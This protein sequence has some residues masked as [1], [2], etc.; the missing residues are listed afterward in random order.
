MK[1]I[2]LFYGSDRAF[3]EI[4]PKSYKNLSLIATQ[5]D[6][7]NKK[8]EMIITGLPQQETKMEKTKKKKLK[9]S[10]FVINADE[11]DSVQEHVLTNFINFIAKLDITN[12]YIQNPPNH[13]QE[14]IYHVYGDKNIISKKTQ[15][16]SILT[17]EIIKKINS[18]FDTRILGQEYVK[19]QLLKTIYPLLDNHQKKP[20]VI[21]FYGDSGLGKT[22]TV[23]YVTQILGGNLLRKQFSMYQNNE[24][25]NYLFGGKYNEKSFAKDLL[26][27]DSNV[28]L[29]DEFDKANTLFHSAF[30][31]LFDEGIYEDHNYVVDV[32][33]TIIFCTSNYLTPEEVKEKL[34][35]PIFNRFDQIIKFNSLPPEAKQQIAK[36]ELL[37]ATKKCNLP[38][39]YVHRIIEESVKFNNAREIKR[40]VKDTV[41]LYE[42]K[43]ICSIL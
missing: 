10:N 14:Q 40:L 18:G 24:F 11:Y 26:A 1:K 36:N 21:L 35:I 41:S 27:R 30:Y 42:V 28:I 25:A 43:K 4:V 12:M 9:I 33:H 31:Q 5:I 3:S 15:D 23:K 20:V 19:M 37:K 22:E 6:E 29:L 2:I 32:K 7:E 17:E 39:K 13:L 8:M 16:Y 38:E 34:G